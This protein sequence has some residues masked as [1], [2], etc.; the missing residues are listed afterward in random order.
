LQL[1]VGTF[2]LN[3]LFSRY[4]FTAEIDAVLD[5]DTQVD[6][7]VEYVFSDAEVYRLRTYQ[8]RLVKAKDKRATEAIRERILR[9]D[10]DVLAI[11]EV[12]DIDTL[13]EFCKVNLNDLYPHR[14]LVEGNDP[15]LI[16]VGVI[17]K[18]P[19]GRVISWQKARHAERMDE[20]VFGRDL[21][22]VEIL[23]A[24]RSKV[25]FSVFNTH[26]KS[27]FVPFDQD[28]V[29]GKKNN[30]TRRRQQAEVMGEV[31]K[32]YV[33]DK[34]R[35][36]V[37]GDMNDPPDS[38]FLAGIA[39]AELGL[40]NGLS[41]PEETRPPKEDNPMPATRAWTHRFKESG[42]PARYELFDHIWVSPKLAPALR[43]AVIDRRSKHSGD[44]SDHDPAW[45]V[46]DL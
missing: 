32:R 5:D 26:L 22:E 40:V 27:H 31:F 14:V 7:A 10:L 17:S 39:A 35:F 46:L 37:M 20:D 21:I 1:K 33:A 28:P 44:G 4:N 8:G 43:G 25:L 15:R 30:D 2:N 45:I 41:D 42:I 36:V 6:A 3:N 24:D 23:K 13:N 11:Q 38:I 18:L 16:D 12:E 29:E 34:R 9:M 19:L